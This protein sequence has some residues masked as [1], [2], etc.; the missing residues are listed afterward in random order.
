MSVRCET[1]MPT[2]NQRLA[3]VEEAVA[4]EVPRR[5]CAP[6]E[7]K[8]RL[9][10]LTQNIQAG[11]LIWGPGGAPM[12]TSHATDAQAAHGAAQRIPD[13]CASFEHRNAVPFAHF[14]CHSLWFHCM[15]E[16]P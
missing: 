11:M 7:L 3:T 12:Q 14:Q 6:P 16:L 1:K 15:T 5:R 9:H 10:Q 13:S 8:V 4:A 2:N